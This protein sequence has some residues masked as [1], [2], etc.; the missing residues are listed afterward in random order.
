[1]PGKL[2]R[3]RASGAGFVA[4]T[5]PTTALPLLEMACLECGLPA[6][7]HLSAE[8]EAAGYFEMGQL[9]QWRCIQAV[10][11]GHLAEAQD[12]IAVATRFSEHKESRVQFFAPG[13]WAHLHAS[14]PNL[15]WQVLAELASS[16]D[17]RVAE[18][19]QAFGVRPLAHKL[20]A[21]VVAQLRPWVLDEN[22]MVRRAAIEATRPRGIWVKRMV[23]AVESPA[24]LLPLLEPMRDENFRLAANST[25]NCLNDIAKDNPELVLEVLTRWKQEG[26]GEQTQHIVQKGLRGLLKAGDTRALSLLGFGGLELEVKVVAEQ[27]VVRPNSAVVYHLH[28]TN[29]GASAK[30]HLAVEICTPGK[31]EGRPRRRR[32]NLGEVDLPQSGTCV[33]R[34]RERVFDTKAAPLID[35]QGAI[36]FF[37]DGEEIAQVEFC[38][39]RAES[40]G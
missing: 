21:T 20:G 37:L 33:V 11:V 7:L 17:L 27:E 31:V 26:K 14:H 25:G 1:M 9:A 30:G 38:L 35:G 19:V 5:Q 40:L 36:L 10:M 34:V 15:A 4:E 12:A 13:M 16:T 8:V 29:L 18:S 6:A 24:L 32:R 23:W 39:K 22:P 2:R 3:R 28:C